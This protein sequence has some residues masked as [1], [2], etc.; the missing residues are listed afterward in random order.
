MRCIEPPLTNEVNKSI[1]C[2]FSLYVPLFKANNSRHPSPQ[3]ESHRRGAPAI[4]VKTKE[5]RWGSRPPVTWER[6]GPVHVLATHTR[7]PLQTT[8]RQAGKRTKRCSGEEDNRGGNARALVCHPPHPSVFT[9]ATE[10]NRC[11]LRKRRASYCVR[12]N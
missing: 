11:D 8:Q 6:P 1:W 3:V 2:L 5:E 10:E 4:V 7:G 12:F 9:W